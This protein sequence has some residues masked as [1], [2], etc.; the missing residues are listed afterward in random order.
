MR[1]TRQAL[2]NITDTA[3]QARPE[4]GRACMLNLRTQLPASQ[5]LVMSGAPMSGAK[6]AVGYV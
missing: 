3:M 5:M 4:Y 2:H 1:L 6:I